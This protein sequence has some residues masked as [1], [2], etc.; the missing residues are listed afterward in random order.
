MS[1]CAVCCCHK[2]CG[3]NKLS[4][5]QP[6]VAAVT[7]HS[8][9]SLYLC[10]GYGVCWLCMYCLQAVHCTSAVLLLALPS[11]VLLMSTLV[12]IVARCVP[13]LNSPSGLAEVPPEGC[14]V[15]DIA[16]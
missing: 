13:H 6:M 1:G 3:V 5:R 12:L 15:P 11:S 9:I 16:L 10:L 2:Q 7:L 14:Q 4:C 8:S